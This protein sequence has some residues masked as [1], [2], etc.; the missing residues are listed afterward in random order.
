MRRSIL[1]GAALASLSAGAYAADMPGTV[2]VSQPQGVSGDAMLYVGGLSLTDTSVDEAEDLSSRLAG[3]AGRVNVWLTPEIAAQFDASG[4]RLSDDLGDDYSVYDGAAHLNWRKDDFL[5]GVFGSIGSSDNQNMDGTF[6]TAGAEAQVDIGQV[7]LSVQGGETRSIATANPDYDVVAP[8]V[9][10]E[11]RYFLTPNL[12]VSGN[13]GAM[14]ETY[15]DPDEPLSATT[16]GAEVEYR[17]DNS[18]ISIFAGYQGS[19]EAENTE[20]R[21]WTK[22]AVVAGLKFNFGTDTLQA[23]AKSGPTLRDYNPITGVQSVRYNNWE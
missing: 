8:Y 19:Y 20:A 7:V 4:E 9:R 2:Q 16:W 21:Y 12:V 18:P 6:V 11:I 17:F 23:A 1:V 13:A 14:Y 15:D 10:G 22:H 5:L 3:G